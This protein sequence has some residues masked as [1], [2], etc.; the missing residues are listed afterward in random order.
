MAIDYLALPVTGELSTHTGPAVMEHAGAQS[1]EP[2]GILTGCEQP[3][4]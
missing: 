4:C 1:T 2:G 3:V